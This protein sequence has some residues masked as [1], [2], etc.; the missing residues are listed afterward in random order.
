MALL[1]ATVPTDNQLLKDYASLLRE[2][3]AKCNELEQRITGTLAFIAQTVTTLAHNIEEL[4]FFTLGDATAG[5]AIYNLPNP[6]L[7]AIGIEMKVKK[8]DATGN[9]ITL[10]A[11]TTTK[12]DN[13]DT[14]ILTLPNEVVTFVSDGENLWL[15]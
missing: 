8:I 11:Y 9:T 15:T 13:Q 7:L 6:A 4:D 1:D 2:I 10:Q 3:R 12:I 14:V 5:N